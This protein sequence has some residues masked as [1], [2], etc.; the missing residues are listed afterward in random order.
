MNQ[1]PILRH[2]Q[3][4]AFSRE[5]HFCLLFCWKIRRGLKYK[6]APERM[7]K[8]VDF[9][10]EHYLQAHFIME[11]ELLF[12]F[13]DDHLIQKAIREHRTIEAEIIELTNNHSE[14]VEKLLGQLTDKLDNHIRYEERQ[15]YPYLEKHLNSMHLQELTSRIAQYR[16]T[17]LSDHYRD[18]F[19]NGS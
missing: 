3:L 1:K 12:V 5:H 19:W 8:Y 18:Q 14:V 15:L 4:L 7:S 9:F 2:A 6:I 17:P 16:A 11:E 10:W 13:P